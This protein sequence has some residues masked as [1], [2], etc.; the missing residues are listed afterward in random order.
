MPFGKW[1]NFI[2]TPSTIICC[3]KM[4]IAIG[5]RLPNA[6]TVIIRKFSTSIEL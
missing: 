5:V 1:R 2:K 4:T 6:R 3:M